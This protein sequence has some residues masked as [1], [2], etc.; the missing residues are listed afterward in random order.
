MAADDLFNE[1]LDQKREVDFQLKALSIEA[2][3]SYWATTQPTNRMALAIG[4]PPGIEVFDQPAGPNLSG[5]SIQFLNI[6]STPYAWTPDGSNL[7]LIVRIQDDAG[8]VNLNF[9]GADTRRRLFELS[10]LPVNVAQNLAAQTQDY[11]DADDLVSLGGAEF[12]D[13]Q[14]AGKPPP[15][16]RPLNSLPELYGLLGWASNRPQRWSDVS[17]LVTTQ[18][19]SSSFNINTASADTLSLMFGLSGTQA[20]AAVERRRSKPFYAI[21]ELG[22][23][24]NNE[25]LYTYANGRF[26]LMI[27]DNTGGLSYKSRLILSPQNQDRP[28]W[29]DLDTLQKVDTRDNT[30]PDGVSTFPK[31]SV[32]S[33]GSR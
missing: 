18:Y 32:A 21:S 26:H 31:P 30:K 27:S 2:E 20:R 23:A 12:E 28:I 3:F 4:A 25:Q 16:N 6:D 9:A 5:K 19:D 8:L 24:D 17:R 7:P 33:N 15:P 22:L 1:T 29:V 11:I 10:G 13:Y 14:R